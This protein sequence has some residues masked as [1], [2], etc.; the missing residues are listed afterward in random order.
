ML[1]LE[2]LS[3][4]VGDFSM[5]GISFTVEKGDYAVILGPTG[6]GKTVLLETIAGI[7]R[8]DS[9]A[10]LIA[11][12]EITRTPPEKR[13]I[14]FVYQ[15]SMLFPHYSVER[16]IRYGMKLRGVPAQE[17]DA[18]LET[19]ADM[20]GISYLLDRDVGNLSGG[21]AQKVALARALAIKPPVLL[22]DEPL[23]PLDP[24]SRENLRNEIIKMHRELGTTIVHVTHDQLTARVMASKIGVMSR[25]HLEQFG[26]AD[27]VFHRPSSEFVARFVG[28]E[29]V[30]HGHARPAVGGAEVELDGLALKTALKVEG[31]VG[32]CV[33]PEMVH[34]LG[35]ND[36]IFENR[37]AGT[38]QEVSDRGAVFRVIAAVAGLRF[39]LNVP[40]RDYEREPTA[41]GAQI[42][43][44]F[45]PENVHC[46]SLQGGA[47]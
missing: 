10:I 15:R 11:G 39:T 46:F 43:I 32:V 5:E 37:L 30:Y 45:T 23:A 1:T 19:L 24:P 27:D 34:L 12:R 26:R 16:N 6:C 2:A 4:N 47:K 25:G 35:P 38:V 22:L 41:P 9:G 7:G 36:N 8:P 18:R 14:G 44:G 28:M 29:N 20:L 42:M 31:R 40:R 3:R 13:N 21:E 17:Q 33:S